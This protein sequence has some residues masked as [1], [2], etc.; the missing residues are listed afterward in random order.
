MARNA[1]LTKDARPAVVLPGRPTN[2]S[3]ALLAWVDGDSARSPANHRGCVVTGVL[4]GLP[5]AIGVTIVLKGSFF[6][7]QI[8][9]PIAMGTVAF[10]RETAVSDRP[11]AL[12]RQHRVPFDEPLFETGR[13]T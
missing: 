10:V 12:Q 4:I 6:G 13:L 3:L 11:E 7:V 5:L 9:D 1:S 2:D 8:A